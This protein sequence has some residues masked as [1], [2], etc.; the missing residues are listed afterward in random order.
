MGRVVNYLRLYHIAYLISAFRGYLAV[1]VLSSPL[2]AA[3]ALVL[4]FPV[5]E[6]SA[7][8]ARCPVFLVVVARVVAF[9]AVV[10]REEALVAFLV[11]FACA[12]TASS[13]SASALTFVLAFLVVAAL[14]AVPRAA[15]VF[16]VVK[17]F[18][19]VRAAFFSSSCK[20]WA[21]ASRRTAITS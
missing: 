13:V 12:V 11:S 3:L 4:F 21:S 2:A 16:S 9:P 7:G 10:T 14:R 1:L 5:S 20:G 18:L 6:V 19:R 15:G 8:V 17:A